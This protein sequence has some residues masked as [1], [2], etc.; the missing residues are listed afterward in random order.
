ME[1]RSPVHE[2]QKAEQAEQEAGPA[3]S[4]QLSLPPVPPTA[5]FNGLSIHQMDRA[6]DWVTTP[7]HLITSLLNVPELSHI[8]FRGTP[9]IRTLTLI[10]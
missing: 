5:P 4:R 10:C 6:P 2:S 3:P 7:N 9:H 1:K 8:S